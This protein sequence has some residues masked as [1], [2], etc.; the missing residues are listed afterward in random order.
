MMIMISGKNV[1]GKEIDI[2]KLRGDSNENVSRGVS[3]I[4]GLSFSGILNETGKTETM[5]GVDNM[6]NRLDSSMAGMPE[7]NRRQ[8]VSVLIPLLNSDVAKGMLEQCFYVF[9]DGKVNV[10]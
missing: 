5:D 8:I 6:M 10:G 1:N 9:P 2:K 7:V 4:R 3:F